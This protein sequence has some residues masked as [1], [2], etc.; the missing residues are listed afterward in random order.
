MIAIFCSRILSGQDCLIFGD[1]EQ[2]RDYVYAG[3]VAKANILAVTAPSGSYNIGTGLETSVN[4]LI[5]ELKNASGM[6]FGVKY[7]APRP[8][9]VQSISL[10]AGRARSVLGWSSETTLAAGIKGTYAW[11]TDQGS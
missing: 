11:F 4:G 1:G 9:E 3:D 7:E 2:T 10:D 8:G 6:D 5:T